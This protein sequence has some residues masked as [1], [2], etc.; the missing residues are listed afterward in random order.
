MLRD[1][2]LRDELATDVTDVPLMSLPH[3]EEEEVLTGIH[4]S[5]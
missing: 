1:R 5:F 4:S 3:I 2:I